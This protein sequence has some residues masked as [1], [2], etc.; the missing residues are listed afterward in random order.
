M[1]RNIY[2]ILFICSAQ[3]C[4]ALSPE[5][6]QKMTLE[7]L[8]LT[9]EQAQAEQA[10]PEDM[11]IDFKAKREDAEKLVQRGIDFMMSNSLDAAFN[12]F[13]HGRDF[14][15]GE[16]YLFVYDQ[17][18]VCLA[19]GQEGNLIW[20]NL[21]ELRDPYGTLIVQRVI[22]KANEGGGWITYSWR[23]AAKVSLVKKVVKDGKSYAIGTGYYPHSKEDAVVS[24][25]KGAVA[26]FNQVK[27]AG[28]PARE[29]FAAFSYPE[30]QF[31]FGDLYLYALDFKGRIF[32]QGDRPGLIG[33]N[34]LEAADATGKKLNKEIIDKLKIT[35]TGDGVWIEYVSKKAQ[36]RAYAEQV[37]DAKGKKYFIACG[38]YP[39]ADRKQAI[40]LVR[41]GFRFIKANGLSA[42][43]E[44]IND[45]RNNQFRYGD[46]HLE[47]Y[48]LEGECL[49]NGGNPE[50]VGKNFWEVTDESGKYY[51][52]SMIEKAQS[53]SGWVDYKMRNL[54]KSTYVEKVDLGTDRYVIACGLYPISK[55]EG[56][57]L[58]VKSAA[59]YLLAHPREK[60]FREFVD[61]DGKFL[62]GD[63]G[64]FVVDFNGLCFAYRDDYNLIWKKLMEVKDDD[65]KAFI[66]LFIN[67]A[68]SGP[69]Q[70]SF[71]L[72]DAR[73]IAYIE[74]VRKDGKSYI[75]GS[76]YYT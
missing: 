22:Q 76:S 3:L 66:R 42:T 20:Q 33:T 52:R 70:V 63:L 46:L 17:E 25:V 59:D 5:E 32:A 28:R 2:A 64:I 49:A 65:G 39:E 53:G 8:T 30:G 27:E 19:H 23:N 29:A 48:T 61:R 73:K 31:V 37:T 57:I 72:N 56:T 40:D 13:S 43:V 74:P 67:T 18:G 68:K 4:L 34:A 69:G 14:V 24:L 62:R 71:R 15:H 9:P 54:F 21:W 26:L 55:R 35:P 36:K 7:Q 16:F 41:Q 58:L 1:K 50:L 75:V 44:L 51:V 45:K 10:R 60:A 47:L 38:Y 11:K 6:Q 12:A